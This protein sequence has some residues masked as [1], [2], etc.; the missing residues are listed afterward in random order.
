MNDEQTDQFITKIISKISLKPLS[1]DEVKKES[2]KAGGDG[3]YDDLKSYVKK[4][5]IQAGNSNA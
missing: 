4:G 5:E 2:K 1:K 3:S